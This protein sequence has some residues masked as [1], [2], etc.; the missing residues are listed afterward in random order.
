MNLKLLQVNLITY[1]VMAKQF[2]LQNLQYQ[3]NITIS[4][5][6]N[7]SAIVYSELRN[8]HLKNSGTRRFIL[9][10]E[11]EITINKKQELGWKITNRYYSSNKEL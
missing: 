5:V 2:Y 10:L 9:T 4:T 7:K 8:L 6:Q 3:Y 11:S 1:H